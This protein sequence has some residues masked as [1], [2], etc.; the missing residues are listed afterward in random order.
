MASVGFLVLMVW[1]MGDPD[2]QQQQRLWRQRE[3]RQI[4]E[5]GIPVPSIRG[6]WAWS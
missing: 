2:G 6:H 4:Q 3:S 5:W 1:V